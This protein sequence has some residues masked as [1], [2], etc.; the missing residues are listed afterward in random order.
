MKGFVDLIL[1]LHKAM[2]RAAARG[3]GILEQLF[4]TQF[5]NRGLF[6]TQQ[7]RKGHDF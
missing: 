4:F 2:V 6:S 7:G 5:E 1:T 3:K